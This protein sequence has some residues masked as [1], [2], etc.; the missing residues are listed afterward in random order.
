[1]IK[2]SLTCKKCNSTF[3][4]WFNTSK[5]YD[6]LKKMNLINCNICGSLKVEKSL[7]SPNLLN[8]NKIKKNENTDNIREVKKKIKE[9]QRYIKNNFNYVGDN[10]THEARS[11][12]YNKKK[13]KKGIFGNASRDEIKELNEEGIETESIPWIDDNEN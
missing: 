7:M 8:T 3:E 1:M 9:Y 4:S 10:F 11:I 2:Y 13:G 5:E 6:R 12:H